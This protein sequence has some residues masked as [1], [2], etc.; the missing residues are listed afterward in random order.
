MLRLL[1]V[2]LM[3]SACAEERESQSNSAPAVASAAEPAMPK[4]GAAPMA[5]NAALIDVP[6]DQAQLKRLVSLGYTV[7]DEHMHKP[8]VAACPKMSD[9]PIQ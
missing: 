4:D 9:D 7:H 2:V 3:L 1:P 6:K 5:T 8:G